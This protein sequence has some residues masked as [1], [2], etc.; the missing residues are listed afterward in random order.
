MNLERS[1]QLLDDS[2]VTG[3]SKRGLLKTRD[4]RVKFSDDTNQSMDF[5]LS[6]TLDPTE[7]RYLL[8]TSNRN[9]TSELFGTT[10]GDSRIQEQS[11][12][13]T[14][15]KTDQLFFQFVEVLQSRTNDSE[16]FE[17][18]QDLIQT[19]SDMIDQLFESGRRVNDKFKLEEDAWLNQ[20]RNTWRL[21]YC[22]Y[23][24]RLINQK[25]GMDL[26]D[27][28][29]MRS[30]KQLVEHLYTSKIDFKEILKKK[31]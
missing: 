7:R 15:Q 24:D 25:E 19:C 14:K 3:S 2:M 1:I 27:L 21:L 8:D 5:D 18:V 10:F 16:V 31:N 23:K 30:E 22:L 26:D 4:G 6:M 12:A 11:F 17:T 9:N 13:Q 28:P 20:E 29:L